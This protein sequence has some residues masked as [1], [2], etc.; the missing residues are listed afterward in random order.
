MIQFA[1]FAQ[2]GVQD[3]QVWYNRSIKTN[4]GGKK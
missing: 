1:F 3:P 4:K 2:N